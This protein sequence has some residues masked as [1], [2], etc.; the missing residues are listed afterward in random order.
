MGMDCKAYKN[1]RIIK[2]EN[3][4]GSLQHVPVPWKLFRK[5][6]PLFTNN[7]VFL[8]TLIQR[9]LPVYNLLFLG[10]CFIESPVLPTCFFSFFVLVFDL[11]WR[12]G[13]G[14]ES[15]RQ[16]KTPPFLPVS[17]SYRSFARW[18]RVRGAPLIRDFGKPMCPKNFGYD[19][20]V[21]PAY[22]PFMWAIVKCH[23]QPVRQ[24]AFFFWREV[25]WLTSFRKQTRILKNTNFLYSLNMLSNYICRE[26]R[27]LKQIWTPRATNK[28][29]K[30]QLKTNRWRAW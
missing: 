16:L 17:M 22:V 8:L 7:I 26:S 30:C 4:I 19:V 11:G 18:R 13:V 14:G 12:G 20:T 21:R 29:A 27:R 15:P 25:G 5:S 3:L 1:K 23:T 10:S 28:Q 24:P 2:I 6:K 9:S